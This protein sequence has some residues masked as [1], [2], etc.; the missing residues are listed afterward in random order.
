MPTD[1]N[2]LAQRLELVRATYTVRGLMF[3][4][5]LDL[6][7]EQA[8]RASTDKLVRE[9]SLPRL[10]DFFSYPAVD[11]LR[12]LFAAADLLEPHFGSIPEAFRVLGIASVQGFFGSSV[13]RAL[14]KIVVQGD[15]KRAFSSTPICYSTM[16]NHGSH[17]YEPLEGN[18]VRLVFRGNMQ[19]APY[20]EGILTAVLSTLGW[21]GRVTSA[22]H[23]LDHTEYIIEW[24]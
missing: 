14:A 13:G 9:L 17:A 5:V 16:M 3:N 12:L 24:D 23:G 21:K 4:A 18:R 2:E 10:N 6:V 11:F 15:P 8:G 1:T 19:P 22:V 7:T 20:H